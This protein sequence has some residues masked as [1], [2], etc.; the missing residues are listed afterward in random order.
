H[1]LKVGAIVLLT[2]ILLD[3]LITVPYL[4]IPYGGSYREFFSAISFWLIAVECLL[5]IYL[6]WRSN[7]KLQLS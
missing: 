2:L 5:I 6:Y 4:I 3:A 1:G 7:V